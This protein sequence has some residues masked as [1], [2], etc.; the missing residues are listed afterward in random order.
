VS[1]TPSKRDLR[2]RRLV[3]RPFRPD[4]VAAIA[5]YADDEEYRRFL[6]RDHPDADEVV[7]HNLRVDWA[8]ERSWVIEIDGEVVGTVFLGVDR[9][10]S[11]GE[12]A[13]L[14][15]PVSWGLGFAVEASRAVIDH[16]FAQ[17][18]LAKVWARADVRHHA[19]IRAMEKLGMR[20]EGLLRS[21]RVG[22][23]GERSDEVVYCLTRDEWEGR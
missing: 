17:L 3:L 5:R 11:V 22:R 16:A 9:A 12:L 4:D 2:T 8:R 19:S 13:C 23:D 18:R 21:Q 7:A 6:G 10:D 1:E 20:R 15:A 14:I